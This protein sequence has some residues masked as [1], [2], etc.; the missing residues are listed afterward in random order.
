G[1]RVVRAPL[2]RVCATGVRGGRR[3]A[4][5][6]AV[7]QG[8]QDRAARAGSRARARRAVSGAGPVSILEPSWPL[9]RTLVSRPKKTA[10]FLAQRIVAEIAD[11]DL[12]AG[13]PLPAERDMLEDYGVA[14]GT[15]R[16]ALRFLEIQGVITI[17]TGPGG[18]PLVGE[19][20]SRHVA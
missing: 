4:P 20:G 2:A 5:A 9:E 13:S 11:R 8:S 14:R 12:A 7:G 16:E 19:P 3:A 10:M 15:L 6:D 1:P 17:K 18:G